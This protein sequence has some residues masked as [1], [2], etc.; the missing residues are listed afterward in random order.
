[1]KITIPEIIAVLVFFSSCKVTE[2]NIAGTYRLKQYPKTRLILNSDKTFEFTKNLPKPGVTVFPDST[3]LNFRTTGSWQMNKKNKLLLNSFPE[4]PTDHPVAIT[5]TLTRNTS[6]SSISFWDAYDDPAPIRFI[7]FPN[8]RIK[9]RFGNSI[10]FFT[11]DFNKKD[12]LEFHFYGYSP[13]TW[14]GRS[15][16][17]DNN[18]H[19][20]ITLNE[21]DRQGFFKNVIFTVKRNKIIST[22]SRFTLIKAK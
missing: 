11:E 22:R 16:N 14:P 4:R 20:K 9:L 10:Y 6:I 3:D 2:E 18:N 21:P 7:K 1:M 17:N 19:Y 15:Y 13:Y 8:N 12:M 5:D